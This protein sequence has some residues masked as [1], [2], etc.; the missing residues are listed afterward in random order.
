LRNGVG[1][2]RQR[3]FARIEAHDLDGAG[4]GEAEIRQPIAALFDGLR[5]DQRQARLDPGIAAGR[6]VDPPRLQF[7]PQRATDLVGGDGLDR[8]VIGRFPQRLLVPA[9]FAVPIQT[10]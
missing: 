8:P 9:E 7:D 2:D 3:S 4:R 6:V 5:I 1:A 10:K